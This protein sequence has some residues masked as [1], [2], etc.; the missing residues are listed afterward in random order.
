MGVARVGMSD[1]VMREGDNESRCEDKGNVSVTMMCMTWA[2]KIPIRAISN[3]R[4]Y[5]VLGVFKTIQNFIFIFFFLETIYKKFK[6]Q[7]K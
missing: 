6:I 5:K 4:E 1:G 7:E 2:L 3:N